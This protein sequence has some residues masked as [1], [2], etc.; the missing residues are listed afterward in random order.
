MLGGKLRG[1]RGSIRVGLLSCVSFLVPPLG[2]W[3]K[4]DQLCKLHNNVLLC[5]LYYSA[6]RF[7]ALLGGEAGVV[8]CFS[9]QKGRIYTAPDRRDRSDISGVFSRNYCSFLPRCPKLQC[10]IMETVL[11]N[12]Y[13]NNMQ[14]K[15]KV[16]PK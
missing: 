6:N 1:R 11:E 7:M 2:G 14:T 10:Y 15:T 4:Q 5:I 16:L 12:A 3:Q 13:S 9:F 8:W